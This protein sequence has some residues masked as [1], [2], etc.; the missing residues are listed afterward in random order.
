[1]PAKRVQEPGGYDRR[2]IADRRA[3]IEKRRRAFADIVR[4]IEAAR[5]IGEHA[6]HVDIRV[7]G[8][9]LRQRACQRVLRDG[10][11]AVTTWRREREPRRR[12]SALPRGGGPPAEPW[13]ALSPQCMRRS[14]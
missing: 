14:R 3:G 4:K 11:R 2:E 7:Q 10:D 1:M 13:W 12:L 5:E 8:R 6:A 9:E